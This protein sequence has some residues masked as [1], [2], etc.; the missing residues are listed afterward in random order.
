MST[1]GRAHQ[2][3]QGAVD[4]LESL[5]LG[6]ADIWTTDHH[7]RTLL[8]ILAGAYLL[9]ATVANAGAGVATIDDRR[10]ACIA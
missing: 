6:G 3:G 4:T 9:P 8:H 10:V 1:R 7:G 2:D 5:L